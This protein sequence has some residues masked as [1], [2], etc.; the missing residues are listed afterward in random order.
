MASAQFNHSGRTHSLLSVCLNAGKYVACTLCAARK[1]KT[2]L[3]KLKNPVIRLSGVW[4]TME[5]GDTANP[6]LAVALCSVFALLINKLNT[7]LEDDE[8]NRDAF[9]LLRWATL[10]L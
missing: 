1:K 3:V 9:L 4:G 5:G 7:Q 10:S 6:R 8:C 2:E